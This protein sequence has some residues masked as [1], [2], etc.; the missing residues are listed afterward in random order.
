VAEEKKVQKYSDIIS[1]VDFVP[2]AIETSG[3]WGSHAL[4]LITEV[5]RRIAGVTHEPRSTMFL[6][7]RI[8]V[9][10]QRG[11]AGCILGTFPNNNLI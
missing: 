2:V 9:A 1:G 4:D 11:N 3:V 7:Q 5:G 10:V 8:S 6:R